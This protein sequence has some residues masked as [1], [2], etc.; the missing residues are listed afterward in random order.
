VRFDLAGHLRAKS[1]DLHAELSCTP[2][3]PTIDYSASNTLPGLV[4]AEPLRHYQRSGT[5]TGSV[6]VLGGDPVEVAGG[7]IRDRTWG[8]REEN[9]HWLEY[10]AFFLC[11]DDFDLALMKFRL[12][13]DSTRVNGHLI[14]NRNGD[15]TGSAVTRNGWGSVTACTFKTSNGPIEITVAPPEARIFLPLGEPEGAHALT[16]YDEFVEA[17]TPDGLIGFGIFEQGILRQLA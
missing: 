3:R 1:G 11:F 4:D 7:C 14:G 8:W 17:T 15:I 6:S 9:Q 2:L 5:V 12:N 10:Y 16:A 13:D